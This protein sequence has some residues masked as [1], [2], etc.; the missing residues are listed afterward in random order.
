MCL[1]GGGYF[2]G[3]FARACPLEV[4]P[5]PPPALRL[6]CRSDPT[7][8][9]RTIRPRGLWTPE[10]CDLRPRHCCPTMALSV[11]PPSPG[12]R[13]VVM[14]MACSPT[15]FCGTVDQKR[16]SIRWRSPARHHPQRRVPKMQVPTTQSDGIC[17]VHP[18]DD[19]RGFV[20]LLQLPIPHDPEGLVAL[21]SLSV[22]TYPW[23]MR[24]W[25]VVARPR[26]SPLRR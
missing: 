9:W 22:H 3:I 25:P 24:E 17:V 13:M 2:V 5:R 14:S 11:R 18:L 26:R 8:S 16:V 12:K 7:L 23:G 19:P 21:Y 1:L 20:V 6:V 10:T 15:G 4:T